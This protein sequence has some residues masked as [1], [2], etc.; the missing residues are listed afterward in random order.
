MDVTGEE[1]EEEWRVRV[2]AGGVKEC[3]TGVTW[4]EQRSE[5]DGHSRQAGKQ[6]GR[7]Q[8]GQASKHARK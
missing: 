5:G 8:A 2:G 7:R 1:E 6:A 3:T 4:Y